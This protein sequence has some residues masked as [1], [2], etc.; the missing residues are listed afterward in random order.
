MCAFVTVVL[1][2]LLTTK[3]AFKFAG[4]LHFFQ[5]GMFSQPL[6]SIIYA[7]QKYL[8]QQFGIP[9]VVMNHVILQYRLNE[10]G[11][12]ALQKPVLVLKKAL[13]YKQSVTVK[14]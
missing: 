7:F 13:D 4:E 1:S 8:H 5:R 3:T 9:V 2:L 10:W 6:P 12:G 11:S 14:R